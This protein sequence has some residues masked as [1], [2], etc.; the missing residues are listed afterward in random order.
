MTEKQRLNYNKMR[1]ALIAI[2]KGYMTPDQLRK[3]S[4]K[5][6]GLGFNECIEMVY[7]NIQEDARIAVKGVKPITNH[8]T[9]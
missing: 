3:R 6:F 4:E 7:E 5:D 1:S 8:K 2:Y 9:V